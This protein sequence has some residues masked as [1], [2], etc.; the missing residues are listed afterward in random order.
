[1]LNENFKKFIEILKI[2]GQKETFLEDSDSVIINCEGASGGKINNSDEEILSF[3]SREYSGKFDCSDF[4]KIS[5]DESF[6]DE[7]TIRESFKNAIESRFIFKKEFELSKSYFLKVYDLL[8]EDGEISKSIANQERVLKEYCNS[9]KFKSMF[10]SESNH[11]LCIKLLFPKDILKPSVATAFARRNFLYLNKINTFANSFNNIVSSGESYFAEAIGKNLYE[12]NIEKKYFIQSAEDAYK[13]FESL[14]INDSQDL[15]EIIKYYGFSGTKEFSEKIS[16]FINKFSKISSGRKIHRDKYNTDIVDEDSSISIVMPDS[17]FINTID[18]SKEYGPTHMYIRK[19]SLDQSLALMS[20]RKYI[21]FKI[22]G[23]DLSSGS[24]IIN[25]GFDVFTSVFSENQGNSSQIKELDIKN[26]ISKILCLGIVDS[27][28][29]VG[30]DGVKKIEANLIRNG[31]SFLT[32]NISE[33]YQNFIKYILSNSEN[34]F[35]EKILNLFENILNKKCENIFKELELKIPKAYSFFWNDLFKNNNCTSIIL[36]LSGERKTYKIIGLGAVDMITSNEH[37]LIINKNKDKRLEDLPRYLESIFLINFERYL[38]YKL[39]KISQE[40]IENSLDLFKEVDHYSGILLKAADDFTEED[41]VLFL[42]C[43]K[44]VSESGKLVDQQDITQYSKKIKDDL[45]AGYYARSL[46]EMINSLKLNISSAIEQIINFE[47]KK[48]LGK[49]ED[50]INKI[51]NKL[52]SIKQLGHEPEYYSEDCDFFQE[53]KDDFGVIAEN[54]ICED[55]ESSDFFKK[56]ILLN[57]TIEYGT[58]GFR[59]ISKNQKDGI[60]NP[61]KHKGFSIDQVNLNKK[62]ELF[63]KIIGLEN[64]DGKLTSSAIQSIT[65]AESLHYASDINLNKGTKIFSIQFIGKLLQSLISSNGKEDFDINKEIAEKILLDIKNNLSS[66]SKSIIDDLNNIINYYGD[67]YEDKEDLSNVRKII[68]IFENLNLEEYGEYKNIKTAFISDKI[69]DQLE[70]TLQMLNDKN[71]KID[72]DILKNIL[73]KISNGKIDFEKPNDCYY[74][75]EAIEF[76]EIEGYAPCGNLNSKI[77]GITSEFNEVDEKKDLVRIFKPSG[78]IKIPISKNEMID[79]LNDDEYSRLAQSRALNLTNLNRSKIFS[80]SFILEENDDIRNK[81]IFTEINYFL[82]NIK[83]ESF[84]QNIYDKVD[85]FNRSASE[86]IKIFLIAEE[87]FL[88]KDEMKLS[89]LFKEKEYASLCLA[90]FSWYDTSTVA[91]T[92]S[93]IIQFIKNLKR[94]DI[95]YIFFIMNKNEYSNPKNLANL[96]KNLIVYHNDEDFSKL[97]ANID[98]DSNNDYIN[99]KFELKIMIDFLSKISGSKSQKIDKAIN[100]FNI[101]HSN[102]SLSFKRKIEHILMGG[103]YNEMLFQEKYLNN[104]PV[105]P[106]EDLDSFLSSELCDKMNLNLVFEATKI[107]FKIHQTFSSSIIYG[108]IPSNYRFVEFLDE[109]SKVID[110]EEFFVDKRKFRDIKLFI[111]SLNINLSDLNSDENISAM[112]IIRKIGVGL[113]LSADS[114]SKNFYHMIEERKKPELF[115]FNFSF[116]IAEDYKDDLTYT[117]E[118]LQDLDPQ[119]FSIGAET[120]CCQVLGGIGNDAAVDSFINEYAGVL[121]LKDD[122]GVLSQSYF[123]WLEK[124]NYLILDNI[125]VARKTDEQLYA[126]LADYCIKKGFFKKVLCGKSYTKIDVEK[127]HTNSEDHSERIFRYSEYTDYNNLDSMDLARPTFGLK[128]YYLVNSYESKNNEEDKKEKSLSEMMDE[129]SENFSRSKNN[130][131]DLS[132]KNKKIKEEIKK[133]EELNEK[134]KEGNL[135]PT[136]G[137]NL[138]T[139]YGFNK[140]KFALF[141]IKKNVE[142]IKEMNRELILIEEMRETF[143]YIDK[144]IDLASKEDSPALFLERMYESILDVKNQDIMNKDEIINGIEKI[145]NLIDSKFGKTLSN[146]GIDIKSVIE[147]ENIDYVLDIFNQMSSKYIDI[148]T[149]YYGGAQLLIRKNIKNLYNLKDKI[150]EIDASIEICN[151]QLLQ[152][153]SIIKKSNILYN[154][155]IIKLSR[156]LLYSGIREAFIK[157]AQLKY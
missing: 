144:L 6:S 5:D 67:N 15:E 75:F 111:E 54:I 33:N 106:D 101:I 21:S 133:L 31:S 121:V 18:E 157:S 73:I 39:K 130:E 29:T 99:R 118:T 63:K 28:T 91:F 105:L 55:K 119:H 124:E 1:M 65:A 11:A 83:D 93:N 102:S 40:N 20:E 43:A 134:Y 88:S 61:T 112:R 117:F 92:S 139:M 36:E 68:N 69:L 151:R 79:I 72:K 108:A 7:N 30:V 107:Y 136:E 142:K 45:S 44:V 138:A 17:I 70:I 9:E 60:H 24:K 123:H 110:E 120:N 64:F 90:P 95:L 77:I 116:K 10:D 2:I 32:K 42:S 47:I 71:I 103:E 49:K 109:I 26:L 38:F 113:E 27:D 46:L 145:Y 53:N 131:I 85:I 152:L 147:K 8:S 52:L 153:E 127:F 50:F 149:W 13:T 98:I 154:N 82:Q 66:I 156:F 86:L 140:T 56:T 74:I 59:N 129:F 126:I 96:I 125:E 51:D 37:D 122:N 58:N 97:I 35:F 141:L 12:I 128:K 34:I 41:L 76:E 150:K 23:D 100:F 57:R 16:L 146:E 132:F 94:M 143:S 25:N 80:K 81:F 48:D 22:N 14:K 115:S 114:A 78:E 87:T 4:S 155:H 62:N 19:E 104:D 148:K 3:K 89:K 137:L 135:K 84:K